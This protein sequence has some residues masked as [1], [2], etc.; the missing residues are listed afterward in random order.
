MVNVRKVLRNDNGELFESGA[1]VEIIAGST[2]GST[3]KGI[4][5]N[6]G[7]KYVWIQTGPWVGCP[8]STE[9]EHCEAQK[10]EIGT[11]SHI[12]EIQPLWEQCGVFK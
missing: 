6:I 1:W 12:K 10:I 3:Y 5:W 7:K 2:Y 4:M 9:G 8:E 11:I